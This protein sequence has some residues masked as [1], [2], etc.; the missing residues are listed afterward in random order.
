MAQLSTQFPARV[1]EDKMEKVIYTPCSYHCILQFHSK[2]TTKDKSYYLIEK[3]KI[4][5]SQSTWL[6]VSS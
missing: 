4:R 2:P 1:T 3:Q 6:N 5:L